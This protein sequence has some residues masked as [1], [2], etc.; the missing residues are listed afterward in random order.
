MKIEKGQ[1]GYLTAERKKL[2]CQA[3]IGFGVVLLILVV[4]YIK[5][6]TRLNIFTVVAV[7]G[8]LPASKMLVEFITIFPYKTIDKKLSD[9]ISE[10]S[11]LLTTAY[12]LVI[13]SKEKIM[14]IN[15]IVISNHTVFGYA[16]NPKTNPDEAASY[17]K[18]V[19]SENN[20]PKTTVKVF[21]E[22]VPFLSRAEGLNNMIEVNH[23][24]DK[25]LEQS[26]RKIILS[27]SM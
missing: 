4:G 7:L 14:P 8:C 18:K 2:G 6:H 13:T 19:L 15:A 26:I 11:A 21:S 5:T 20:Y 27:V 17:I 10:K 24:A 9:E 3:L 25:E 12:D 22:Y 23:S 1:A 16:K